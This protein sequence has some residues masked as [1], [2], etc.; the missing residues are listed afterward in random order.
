MSSTTSCI[1]R[2]AMGHGRVR[3]GPNGWDGKR[4]GLANVGKVQ[5][6]PRTPS[7]HTNRTLKTLM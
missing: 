6:S 5:A 7:A 3:P 2:W 4:Q 1:I